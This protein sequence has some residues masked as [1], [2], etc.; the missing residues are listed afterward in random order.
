MRHR[1][2]V[3]SSLVAIA[4]FVLPAAAQSDSTRSPAAAEVSTLPV[5]SASVSTVRAAIP[6]PLPAPHR[7]RAPLS[8]VGL[9][10][11]VGATAK[12]QTRRK[13]GVKREVPLY[14]DSTAHVMRPGKDDKPELLVIPGG[15][16][17][18]DT[19]L[20]DEEI[21]E[22]TALRVI[23]HATTEEIDRLEQKGIDEQRAEMLRTQEGEINQLKAQQ[24][25]ERVDLE[26]KNPSDEQRATQS[27]RHGK[28]LAKLQEK[29]SAALAKLDE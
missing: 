15:V 26:A 13:A 5:H 22:L 2:A 28:Q 8:V 23:R 21:D 1:F 27:D 12:R 24:D 7:E 11:F 29:H 16:L 9:G 19:D 6:R 4:A 3:L 18:D 17:V 25:V 20:T 10:A 14:L